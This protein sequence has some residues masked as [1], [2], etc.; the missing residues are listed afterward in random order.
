MSTKLAGRA[1]T[2]RKFQN[3]DLHDHPARS[4]NLASSKVHVRENA[5]SSMELMMPFGLACVPEET[6]DFIFTIMTPCK[7]LRGH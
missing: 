4:S 5:D 3:M 2:T 6:S 1:T 7:I